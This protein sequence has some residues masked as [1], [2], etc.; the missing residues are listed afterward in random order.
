MIEYRVYLLL[1]YGF[2]HNVD[3]NRLFVKNM[4]K[5]DFTDLFSNP[6][7]YW[8]VSIKICRRILFETRYSNKVES[9]K[10]F[11]MA[12]TRILEKSKLQEMSIELMETYSNH[13]FHPLE[14]D[15][16]NGYMTLLY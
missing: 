5:N 4:S 10:Y 13:Q 11:D 16:G 8:W 1:I 7:L 14:L 9:Y 2:V 6:P 3:T 12:K 15:L